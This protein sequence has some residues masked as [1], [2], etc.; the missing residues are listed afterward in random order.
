MIWLP[1]IVEE[2]LNLKVGIY[3][4]SGG[5]QIGKSTLLKQWILKLLESGKQSES[6]L[7]LSGELIDS[8]KELVILLREH[9]SKFSVDTLLYIVCDEVTYIKNWDQG[10][11]FLA[12]SAELDNVVL[13][14]S[15][16]DS[17]IIKEARNRFPGRRGVE[18]KTDFH[19]FPLS[20]SEV[21]QL[22]GEG[23]CREVVFENYLLHGGFLKAINDFSIYK[24]IPD[25]TYHIY[26]QWILGD[27]QKKGKQEGYVLEVLAAIIKR[28]S[29]QVSWN[30][31]AKDLSIDHHKTVHD[32]IHLLSDFDVVFIQSALLE[33]KLIGAPKKAK[34]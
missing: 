31:L 28:S 23:E 6:I 7:Y 12:D 27:M 16:S 26:T 18:S 14:L 3:T 13:M 2:L 21:I 17:S 20:F 9:I 29:T 5:R 19:C 8:H 22:Y 34:K 15:G 10:V 30:S 4:L 33:N 32:Y 24:S 1:P 11:K 25:S